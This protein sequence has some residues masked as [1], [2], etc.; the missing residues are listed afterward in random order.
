MED[1][2]IPKIHV[3]NKQAQE[4]LD[5][6]NVLFNDVWKYATPARDILIT[7]AKDLVLV[8]KTQKYEWITVGTLELI[9]NV[10]K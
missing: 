3:L 10:E 2:R 1:G 6:D 4:E 9:N 8:N 5:H 7:A